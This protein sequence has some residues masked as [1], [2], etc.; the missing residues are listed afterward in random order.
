MEFVLRCHTTPLGVCGSPGR[1][2]EQRIGSSNPAASYSVVS[3]DKTLHLHGSGSGFR[4]SMLSMDT[5][6]Q[7]VS[8]PPD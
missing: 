1:V 5:K 8:E 7:A 6:G 4:N 2:A 3:L